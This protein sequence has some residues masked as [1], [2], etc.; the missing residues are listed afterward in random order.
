MKLS[1]KQEKPKSN[2]WFALTPYTL[3]LKLVTSDAEGCSTWF[4]AYYKAEVV[5]SLINVSSKLPIRIEIAHFAR[6]RDFVIQWITVAAL[7][8]S[9]LPETGLFLTLCL[10]SSS[11]C[12]TAPWSPARC[13]KGTMTSGYSFLTAGALDNNAQEAKAHWWKQQH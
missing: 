10:A 8:F 12:P 5:L 13:P 11:V 2:V 3:S 6:P 9:L 7:D 1:K 4:V